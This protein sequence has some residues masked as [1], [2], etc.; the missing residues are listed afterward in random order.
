MPYTFQGETFDAVPFPKMTPAEVALVEH[1]TKQSYS[2]LKRSMTT[3]VCDHALKFHGGED[4]D[5]DLACKGCDC[6]GFDADVPTVANYALLF[7]AL[8][9]VKPAATFNEVEATPQ[10]EWTFAPTAEADADPTPP[11]ESLGA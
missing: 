10:D 4:D 2:R 11:Q 9:R 7:I 3:C 5:T 6:D 8:R 1:L